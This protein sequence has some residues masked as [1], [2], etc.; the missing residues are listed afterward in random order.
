MASVEEEV[1]DDAALGVLVGGLA[2]AVELVLDAEV[3][4]LVEHVLGVDAS[5]ARPRSSRSSCLSAGLRASL[6]PVPR[7]LSSIPCA[8]S[9]S[10]LTA[11]TLGPSSLLATH[12]STNP[13]DSGLS[14]LLTTRRAAFTATD[15]IARSPPRRRRLSGRRAQNVTASIV[16]DPQLPPISKNVQ[17]RKRR[18]CAEN[19]SGKAQA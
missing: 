6:P 10:I 19:S 17:E 8:Y 15:S 3:V 12:A 16:H 5:W 13:P 18:Q 9:S 14:A 4:E 2:G 7:A 1:V 11:P